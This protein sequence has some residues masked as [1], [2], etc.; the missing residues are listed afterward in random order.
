MTHPVSFLLMVQINMDYKQMNI[1]LPQVWIIVLNFDLKWEHF[2][3]HNLAQMV[4]FEVVKMAII[5][6]FIWT[7][8]QMEKVL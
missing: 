7:H 8:N 3:Q 4:I 2:Q 1:I 6:L 5:W